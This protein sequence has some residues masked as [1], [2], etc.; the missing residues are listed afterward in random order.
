MCT[1][2]FLKYHRAVTVLV[3]MSQH[4][5]QLLLHSSKVF[6]FFSDCSPHFSF[7]FITSHAHYVPMS[8]GYLLSGSHLTRMHWDNFADVTHRAP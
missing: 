7:P 8:R 1:S 3:L 2:L 5:P 4:V 6:L